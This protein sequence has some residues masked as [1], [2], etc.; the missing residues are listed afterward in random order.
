MHDDS[1]IIFTHPNPK[2]A[3]PVQQS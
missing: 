3:A 2:M 1:A